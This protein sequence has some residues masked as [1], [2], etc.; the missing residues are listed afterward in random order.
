MTDAELAILSIIAEGPIYGY[1]LQTVIT[2]RGLRAWTNIGVSSMYYVVEKLERQGLIDG[3]GSPQADGLT[4]RQ[5]QITPAGF[6]VLQTAVADLLSTPREHANGFELGLAN[7]H[8]LRPSQIRTAFIAYRQE[9]QSRLAQAEERLSRLQDNNQAPFYVQAMFSHQAA[10][11]EAELAWVIHFTE[12]W[13]AQAPPD[14]A[15]PPIPELPE[16]PRMKQ[17]VLPHDPDSPHRVPTR[18]LRP[19]DVHPGPAGEAKKT[20]TGRQTSAAGARPIQSPSGPDDMPPDDD[21][22]VAAQDDPL[23]PEKP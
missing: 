1:D 19:S 8:V 7:L 18:P 9:L 12:A 14:D 13:E 5:Y 21:R 20:A 16:I 3:Q 17:V 15:P 6:G 23:L 11:L 22:S 2:Q 4:R 10:M